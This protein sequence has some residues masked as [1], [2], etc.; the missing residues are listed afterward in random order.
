[1]RYSRQTRF[2]PIGETGQTRLTNSKVLVV[3]AGALG[4]VVLNHLVRAGVGFI[5]I[6]DRDYIEL[7]NLQRQML[8]D[9]DDVA[10][11]LPKA[12]AAKEKLQKMNSTIKIE[13]IVSHVSPGNIGDLIADVDLVIDGTDNFATRYVLNDACFQKGIPFSYGGVVSA[14]GMTALFRPGHTCCLRCMIKD[15]AGSNETCD[16]VGVISPAVDIVGSIQSTD[17]LK[18]LTGNTD[19]IKQALTT[20]DMWSNQN[21]HINFP[22]PNPDCPTCQLQQYPALHMHDMQET[23]LCG[24]DTVQ[25]HHYDSMDLKFWDQRLKSVA[26]TQLTPFILKAH[27]SDDVHFTIFPDGR[28]L[29]QGTEDIAKART[30]YDRYI[31]S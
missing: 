31:G 11:A 9:E 7:S 30:L 25:I 27:V 15:T 8:Y 17:A 4:T 10:R 22:Q 24:R 13:A 21:M 16:M 19:Q 14:R 12:L 28:V 1:M 20:F 26:Q 29:V 5:R 18:L 23:V 3:G 2:K 6:V